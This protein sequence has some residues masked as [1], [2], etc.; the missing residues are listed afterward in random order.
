MGNVLC[1]LLNNDLIERSSF[2]LNLYVNHMNFIGFFKRLTTVTLNDLMKSVS[3]PNK[4]PIAKMLSSILGLTW[5][6]R[7]YNVQ[8]N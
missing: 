1:F 8:N 6:H 7:G 5:L 4:H 3:Q 2:F